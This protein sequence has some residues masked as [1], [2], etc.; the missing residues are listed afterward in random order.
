[1][2]LVKCGECGAE[3]SDKADACVRCGAPIK[4]NLSKRAAWITAGVVVVCGVAAYLAATVPKQ[5]GGAPPA[6]AESSGPKESA[7]D[8]AKTDLQCLGD[9]GIVGASV[10]CKDPVTK[11]AKYDVKWT[12]RTFELKFSRFRW[13]DQAA[14]VI[15]YVGDK[16]LF[17][18]GFGAYTPVIYECDLAADNKTVLDV[19]VKEGRLP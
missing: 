7:S 4:K 11:L 13:A 8:C 3:I 2:A 16:A 15:T 14:G 9:K 10:Y 17:Q 19:R 1:M 6:A 12:D 18:N 5:D